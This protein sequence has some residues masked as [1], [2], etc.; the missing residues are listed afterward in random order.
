MFA[1]LHKVICP[2][3][4][5]VHPAGYPFIALFAAFGI[6]L[7]WINDLLGFVGLILTVWCIYF[8][9]DPVRHTPQ[10]DGLVISPADG[11]I[12]EVAEIE[13]PDEIPLPYPR[14][15]KI[16]VFMN[17]FDI[18]VNRA[19]CSGTITDLGYYPGSFLDASLD[20]TSTQN[21]RQMMVMQTSF[22]K[23]DEAVSIAFVQIA[24]LVARRIICHLDEGQSLRAGA[25]F[26]LIRFGSRVDVYLPTD[27]AVC[28]AV[29]QR[30]IAGQT[31][32]GHLGTLPKH[33]WPSVTTE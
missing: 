15:L 9:R 13:V 27:A 20:K 32:L 3:L 33:G 16:G 18:H 29:G 14:A 30:M 1:R 26:G 21:E 31:V 19:P 28:V 11:I 17:V 7:W 22:R 6:L 2:V 24:G 4:H 12:T 10:A 8:F 23:D 25:R 5:P